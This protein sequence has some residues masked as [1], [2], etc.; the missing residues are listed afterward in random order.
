MLLRL[1]DRLLFVRSCSPGS[2]ACGVSGGTGWRRGHGLC[3]SRRSG[4]K[5]EAGGFVAVVGVGRPT[6]AT[7]PPHV[8]GRE[9]PRRPLP[10][11]VPYPGRSRPAAAAVRRPAPARDR[12]NAWMSLIGDGS[13][14]RTARDHV[15]DRRHPDTPT[16]W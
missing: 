4:L 10:P 11:A 8:P 1:C 5:L 14:S 2:W 13:A 16:T 3:L 6:T 7:K 15:T 9:A 12:A